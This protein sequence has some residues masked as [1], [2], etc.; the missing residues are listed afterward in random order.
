MKLLYN[1]ESIFVTTTNN[2][3]ILKYR[4]QKLYYAIIINNC[5]RYSSILNKQRIDVV[6]VDDKYRVL[7]IKRTMHE[8]TIY[9][10]E[11]ASK[12]ILLPLGT[13]SSLRK[14]DYFSI[15]L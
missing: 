7:S 12:T 13:F 8:N 2:I 11:D 6:M 15:E 9:E 14:N 4:F 1:E 10:D 5:N 3:N